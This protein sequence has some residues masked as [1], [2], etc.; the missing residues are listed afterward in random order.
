MRHKS[1]VNYTQIYLFSSPPASFF[2]SLPN[3]TD[4]YNLLYVWTTNWVF[5]FM[6]LLCKNLSLQCFRKWCTTPINKWVLRKEKNMLGNRG[7][8]PLSFLGQPNPIFFWH[9]HYFPPKGALICKASDFITIYEL[10][11]TELR[12]LSERKVQQALR[13]C[14]MSVFSKTKK[15]TLE[16]L[17][18][19]MLEKLEM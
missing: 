1:F 3:S 12:W 6:G 8:L 17:K 18:R 2:T 10:I 14:V 15:V 11:I 9:A 5:S 7:S 13:N 4:S 19:H 16:N